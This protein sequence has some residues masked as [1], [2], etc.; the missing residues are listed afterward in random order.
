[1]LQLRIPSLILPQD[2]RP[3]SQ[4]DRQFEKL[5]M[6]S[7]VECPVCEDQFELPQHGLTGSATCPSCQRSFDISPSVLLDEVNSSSAAGNAP[8]LRASPVAQVTFQQPATNDISEMD[9][10]LAAKFGPSTE[11]K[12]AIE[13][14]SRYDSKK[15]SNAG[16]FTF[17]MIAVVL[18]TCVLAVVLFSRIRGGSSVSSADNNTE[19]GIMQIEATEPNANS[20]R[21]GAADQSQASA[22]ENRQ[23]LR[24][25]KTVAPQKLKHFAQKQVDDCWKLTQPH[26]L[27]LLIQ[28]PGGT[29]QATGT[30]VDSRGWVVTSYQAVKDA[31]RIE[32]TSA[33]KSLVDSY[34]NQP[35]NDLARGFIATDPENDLALLAVNRRFVVSFADVEISKNSQIVAGEHLLQC[36]PPSTLR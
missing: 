4:E 25:R 5:V 3:D 24:Q 26:L 30:I 15:R 32:V 7:I 2:Q 18:I 13:I 10:S 20:D 34:G 21:D 23:S 28:G 1:M 17:G 31:W 14:R 35:L 22:N 12:R 29:R 8:T 9:Q 16:R 11:T 6:N 33:A 19:R 36:G 27:S